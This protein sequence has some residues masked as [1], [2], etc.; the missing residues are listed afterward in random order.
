MIKKAVG[1]FKD[2]KQIK[3][4]DNYVAG[5]AP[6]YEE[7]WKVLPESKKTFDIGCAYG[8]MSLA[9]KLRGD[10]VE[11]MDMTA[12]FTNLQMLEKQGI[13]FTKI[14]LEKD[15]E[16]P[17]KNGKPELIIFTE[18]LEHLN[19]NPLPTIKKMFTTLKPGGYLVCS[20][21]ARELFGK[22]ETLNDGN[23]PGLWND[24]TSWRDIPEYKGKWKDQHTFHY[25]QIDL[26][27]L[28][29]EAGFEVEDIKLIAEFSHLIIARKP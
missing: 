5:L 12:K 13:P 10:D 26:V 28:F 22:P 23:K 4:A 7:I 1:I 8:I 25:S 2:H 24:L 17:V 9:C 18:V 20:T 6:L 21:P 3:N 19:S 16:I 14:N 15:K 11:A 27:S 29:D